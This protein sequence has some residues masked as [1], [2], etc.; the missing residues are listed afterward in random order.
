MVVVVMMMM[1]MMIMMM[2]MMMMMMMI[3]KS[4]LFEG[5]SYNPLMKCLIRHSVEKKAKE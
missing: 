1:M 3:D 5:H 2:M 4:L